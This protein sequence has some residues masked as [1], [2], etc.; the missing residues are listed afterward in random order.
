MGVLGN[1]VIILIITLVLLRALGSWMFR[2]NE[3][4]AE[5]KELNQGVSVMILELRKKGD[6]GTDAN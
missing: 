1:A 4:I 2:I 5:L 3:V 6:S